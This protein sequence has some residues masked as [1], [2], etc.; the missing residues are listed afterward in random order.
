M[1][2]EGPDTSGAGLYGEKL[3]YMEARNANISGSRFGLI[4]QRGSHI[5]LEGTGGGDRAVGTI[6]VG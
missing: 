1:A 5:E 6:Q 4:S 2:T 3:G